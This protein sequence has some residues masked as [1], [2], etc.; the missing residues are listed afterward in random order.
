MQLDP[1]LL[2]ILNNKVAAVADEMFFALQRASRSAYVKEGADFG[3]ALLDVNGKVFGYPPSTTVQFLLDIE[4]WPTI[5]AVPD[6]EEGDVI[7][8]ND[9]YMTQGLSTHL[10]DIHMIRPYF[11]GGQTVAYGWCF[12]HAT[13]IGGRVPSSISPSNHEIFQEGLR[14]PPMKFVKKGTLNDDV[15]QVFKANCRIPETNMGDLRAMLGAMHTGDQRIAALIES[16]GIKTFLS[17]Q[18]DLQDYTAN[19]AR[20]V[21]RLLPDGEYEFW[22]Y[23]DDDLVSRI[24]IRIRVK[25]TVDDGRVNINVTHTD[26]QVSAAYNVPTANGRNY[27]L[28]MRITTFMTTHDQ[29]MAM[30][31]GL[32]RHITVTNPPGTVMNAEFPDAVGV[33]HATARRLNDAMT[34]AILKAAPD[35]MAAPTCGASCP[36]VLAEYNATGTKR[37]VMVLEPMR[38][39]M[40]ARNGHDGVDARDGAM[41]NM[42]NHPIEIVEA[43]AAVLIREY[44]VCTDSGG[45]GRWRGGVGQQVTVEILRDGGTILARGMERLRF[46]AW[47]VGGGKPAQPFRAILNRGKPNEERLAKIDELHVNA[48]DTVTILNPGASSYGDPYLRPPETVRIDAELGFISRQGAADDYGVV[49]TDEG[50]VDKAATKALRAAR[51]RDNRRTDFDFGPEREAWEAVFDDA[52]MRELNRR[53]YT[54]PKSV[55]QE[56]R[57]WIFSQAV[58]D[59]P[60][61]GG[62]PLT[63]TMGDPDAIRARLDGAMAEV[64]GDV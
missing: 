34:G 7:I 11:H 43:E 19:K 56:K 35:L 45:P 51:P 23:M 2:E 52:V 40:G 46:P 26:P 8:A 9:P 18:K 24:P 54:L 57:R 47:G 25:M 32:Y 38:G 48:G 16:H 41:S 36:M 61:A 17:C 29:T 42:Q 58:P 63:Q 12:I 5:A 59:L 49:I 27:W 39:G 37:N 15:A 20:D 30:N 31:A 22:D 21:L 55:R 10:P 64:F 62:T 60:V 13:D 50:T 4:C 33:R 14:I 28:T 44:D 6:L 53:L 3:V 1:I